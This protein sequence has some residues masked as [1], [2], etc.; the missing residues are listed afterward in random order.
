VE[1]HKLLWRLYEGIISFEIFIN[2]ICTGYTHTH[3]HT[4]QWVNTKNIAFVPEQIN[5]FKHKIA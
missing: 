2:S 1:R 5:I 4:H 3:T